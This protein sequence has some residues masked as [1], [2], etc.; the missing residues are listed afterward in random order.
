MPIIAV[1]GDDVSI[2]SHPARVP[3]P[4]VDAHA[5]RAA[6]S[7]SL[8]AFEA[9]AQASL[10][11][12]FRLASAIL[13]DEAAAAQA[14]QDALVAAWRTLPRLE[15]PETFDAW[16]RRLL[17]D[18]CRME[19]RRRW[20]AA[21]PDARA[22]APAAA[23]APLDTEVVD[24]AAVLDVLEARYERLDPDDR[25]IVAL[26][27]LEGRPSAEIAGLMHLPAGTVKLRLHEAHA[28]LT[29]ALETL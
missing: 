11:P 12:A 9:L 23:G 28:A 19:L 20:A 7:G 1:E 29:G 24:R 5:V 18:A 10:A 14:T 6:A 3:D 22:A 16:F 17:V 13:G 15:R 4:A 8:A 25:A 2:V 27:D 26:H 21:A